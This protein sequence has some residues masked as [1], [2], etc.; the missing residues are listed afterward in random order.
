MSNKEYSRS[1]LIILVTDAYDKLPSDKKNSYNLGIAL[2]QAKGRRLK[3]LV[4]E[5]SAIISSYISDVLV[6][7]FYPLLLETHDNYAGVRKRCFNDFVTGVVK[8]G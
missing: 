6:E 8:A 4:Q 5:A 7:L 1:D 2:A 3:Q